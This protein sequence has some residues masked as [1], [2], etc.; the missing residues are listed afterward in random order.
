MRK[1]I[2]KLG[3]IVF[4][5][6]GVTSLL[7]FISFLLLRTP[8]VQTWLSKKLAD[9]I[10]Q[11]LH[12]RVTVGGVNFEFLKTLVLEEVF[13][14]DRHNDT[15]IWA[16][17]LKVDIGYLGLRDHWIV[18]DDLSLVNAKIK[19]KKYK[20]E[21]DMAYSFLTDALSG[22]DSDT[23]QPKGIQ[24][25]FNLNTLNVTNMEFVYDFKQN[26]D[27]SWG[28]N[29]RNIHAMGV[30]ARLADI[31]VHGD[32]L[33]T[34]VVY[35]SCRE[36]CGF[37]LKSMSG[38][39]ELSQHSAEFKNLRVLTP[40]SNVNTYL[41][42]TYHDPHGF[43]EFD[44]SV[45]MKAVF[46]PSVVEMADI[47]YFAPDLRGIHKRLELKK[48]KVDG[49]VINLKGKDLE[50]SFGKASNFM[51]DVSFQGLPDIDQT[52]II[53][54]AKAVS[55]N[56]DD[57][58]QMPVPPFRS[59]GLLKLPR[60][61]AELGN[62]RFHGTWEGFFSEF[63]A[64]GEFDTG[65]GSVSSDISLRTNADKRLSYSG[66]LQV[67]DF[68][69]G[70]FFD[71][72]G[73][74]RVSMSGEFSGSDVNDVNA[75]VQLK[76]GLVQYLELNKYTY[77]NIKFDGG[78]SRNELRGGMS[79]EDDNISL[80]YKGL[81][82][83]KG[84]KP[85][86]DFTAEIRDA[87]LAAL[88]FFHGGQN[89]ML[90]VKADVNLAG[91]NL[92]NF[93]GIV[94][95]TD[96]RYV[97]DK[98][99]AA[100]PELVMF[101]NEGPDRKIISLNSD[102]IDA[103][104]SGRFTLVD[105]ADY[106]RRLLAAYLPAFF[107]APLKRVRNAEQNEDFTYN[108][109]LKNTD[110]IST[111]F[112]PGLNAAHNTSINGSVNTELKKLKVDA[113]SKE[114]GIQ[115]I[116]IADW[117]LHAQSQPNNELSIT[118]SSSRLF[119]N[120]SIGLDR[121]TLSTREQNDSIAFLMDWKNDSRKNYSGSIKAGMK[122]LSP[123]SSVIKI[124]R[125]KIFVEDSLWKENG[126]NLV[127]IDSSRIGFQDFSLSNNLQVLLLNGV[128][129]K[130]KNDYLSIAV[131]KFN[132][133]GLNSLLRS[134]GLSLKGLIDSRTSVSDLYHNV[135]FTSSSSFSSLR[136]NN[137]TIGSGVLESIWD[138]KKEGIYLHGS[139]SRGVFTDLLFSGNYYPSRENNSLDFEINIDRMNLSIFKPYVQDY[140]KNFEGHFSGNLGLKGSLHKPILIG[141]VTATGEKVTFTYLNTNYHFKDQVIT[142][143]EH[144][145]VMSDFVILDEYGNEAVVRNGRLTHDNFRN[146]YLNFP[147]DTK[148]FMCLN[149]TEA[150]NSDYYGTA[151]AS[152][153]VTVSGTVD[154]LNIEANVK[155]EKN[156][157]KRTNRTHYT[158]INIP[159][160][161]TQEVS[162]TNF[163]RFV[164][165]DSLK[166]KRNS[167]Y[168]V[169][170]NGISL[171]FNLE[172][173]P[174]A[175]IQLIFDQKTGDVIKA[176]G[177]GNVQMNI[178]TLGKFTMLGDYS[179]ESGEYLFTLRNLINKKFKIE[180]GG[181]ISWAGEP[182]DA[183]INLK[184][185]YQLRASLKPVVQTDTSGRRYPVNCI[186]SLSGNLLQ[187]ALSFEI[188]IPTVD[189]TTQQEVKRNINNEQ[190]VNRQV[191]ALLVMNNFVAP[192]GFDAQNTGTTAVNA[193]TSELLSN[194]LSNW[195]S[196]IS[197]DFDL[198]V[199]YRPAT[200]AATRDEME[201]AMSTQV[202]N[203]RLVVDGTV[204]SGATNPKNPGT[205]NTVGDLSVE[206]KLT[207]NGK[208]RLKA[209]NKTNDNTVLNA[210]APYSQGVGLT[211]KE[212]FNTFDELLKRYRE[213]V[214]QF[215]GKKKEE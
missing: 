44:D 193:T 170:M 173:T 85:L 125:A 197:N 11:K 109:L 91:D 185:D 149:T 199:K 16:P 54:K 23:K 144:A 32:T 68:N 28:M 194:Q 166:F 118:T 86:F 92:D 205:S 111:C 131:N 124:E 2:K 114:L 103:S 36:R 57:L 41:L 94:R 66:K 129:S 179:I 81:I 104:V 58:E 45:T 87:N 52:Y 120:D 133:A 180:K 38:V 192:L 190:E 97:Q 167:I 47:A 39:A 156:F 204:I 90:S 136:V 198:S 161:N 158:N 15:I 70:R 106:S 172:V 96:L 42:F 22:P 213:K 177:Q 67:R 73:F 151:F 189:E 79:M 17:K 71:L 65:L 49:K 210:D 80:R 123:V 107:N 140:C 76:N 135:I 132:L 130:D 141:S 122:I 84:K 169:N 31:H 134:D 89:A 37:I 201:L 139:F 14:A 168:N 207:K 40:S 143:E 183:S 175:N 159:L 150:D 191:L 25:R 53:L 1:S 63:V 74:N 160:E 98:T 128:I 208:L 110:I 77:K 56:T 27:T 165:K 55:T 113:A 34:E 102:Y 10:S 95:L 59:G 186:M 9:N 21:H 203:D 6:L 93:L 30:N 12:T 184:A 211:Y 215:F 182:K 7:L 62:I 48:G 29:Y 142:L 19:L 119:L 18:L 188:E 200:D 82:D 61:F 33:H 126:Q 176:K 50:V 157:D 202:L 108:I 101:A 99:V 145:F 3:K 112:F 178:N 13:I 154:Q 155:T 51:G 206:Y 195:L 8:A 116:R 171:N 100:L 75:E 174:D 46:N 138:K 162:Q 88:H 115:G 5:F 146:F 64:F 196:Q 181:T 69:I 137:D 209:Y 147:I 26:T 117:N 72:P 153:P 105:F 20:G 4:Y 35:L 78:F 121:L 214:L 60:N 83:F 43:E 148:G 24:W 212:D 152:G 164:K 187:P 127:S 163:I